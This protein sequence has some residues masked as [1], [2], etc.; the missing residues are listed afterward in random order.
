MQAVLPRVDHV[1]RLWQSDREEPGH[2]H[3]HDGDDDAHGDRERRIL[4]ELV[5][6]FESADAGEDAAQRDPERDDTQE[7]RESQHQ[8]A[9]AMS[10]VLAEAHD[11]DGDHRQYAGRGVEQRA[12]ESRNQTQQKQPDGAGR[13][14]LE[15]ET[16]R[17]ELHDLRRC[18]ACVNLGPHRGVKARHVRFAGLGSGRTGE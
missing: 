11:L 6:R 1:H 13:I 17:S 2:T 3:G 14:D 7:H 18:D 4:K 5:G 15:V 10:R 9:P 16:E 8:R 12:A